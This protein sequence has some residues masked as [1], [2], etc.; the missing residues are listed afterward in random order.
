MTENSTI[1]P[2][3][4]N[5]FGGCY[6]QDVWEDF[7][8]DEEVWE[9]YK[10]RISLDRRQEIAKE[11]DHLLEIDENNAMK[12]L[13]EATYYGGIDFETYNDAVDFLRNFKTFLLK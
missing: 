12:F 6:H 7:S 2:R 13:N 11:I 9:D 1:Y 4:Y 8:T 10:R 5:F 3:I